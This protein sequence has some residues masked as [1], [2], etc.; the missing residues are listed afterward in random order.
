MKTLLLS[1]ADVIETLQMRDA[2]R[3]VEE[4]FV[5]FA[6]QDLDMPQRH[7]I[8]I[9]E[10]DGLSAFMPCYIRG[11]GALGIKTVSLFRRNRD[12]GLPSIHGVVLLIDSETGVVA[13][14]IDG[15]YLTAVRTGAASGVA[16][17]HLARDDAEVVAILGAGVQGMTQL[18]AVSEVR[19]IATVWVYDIDR[20][21]AASYAEVMGERGGPIPTEIRVAASVREAIEEADVICTATTSKIPIFDGKDLRPG[22]HVNGIGSHAPG[23]RELDTTTILR[24]KVVCDDVSACLEE[25]GDL[26]IPIEEGMFSPDDIYGDLGRRGD[27]ALQIR[28]AGTTGRFS[29]SPG[30]PSSQGRGHRHGG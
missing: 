13:S 7:V 12:L 22:V 5:E 6:S 4:A 14:I 28:W 11:M 9:P 25:A 23:I 3:A 27:N 18:E 17:K 21:A 29:C 20:E 19:G 30:L 10:N 26:L 8:D 16:T 15:A 2:I 24:S 1:Q